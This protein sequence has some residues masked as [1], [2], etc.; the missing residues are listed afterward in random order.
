MLATAHALR[1]HVLMEPGAIAVIGLV[2][3]VPAVVIALLASRRRRGPIQ[4]RVPE[5]TAAVVP[6]HAS[7]QQL[8]HLPPPAPTERAAPIPPLSSAEGSSPLLAQGAAG[9]QTEG[10]VLGGGDGSQA[11]PGWYPDPQRDEGHR[12]WDG[13]GW[14]DHLS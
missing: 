10:R 2:V 9:E 6:Q 11:R 1:H 14:T 7:N 4:E 3:V 13:K 8:S 12:W 5:S